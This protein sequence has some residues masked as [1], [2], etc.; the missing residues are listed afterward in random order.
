MAHSTPLERRPVYFA[1]CGGVECA[2]LAFG[3]LIA[4]SI[5]DYTTWRVCFYIVIP[6]AVVDIL[7]ILF[8]TPNSADLNILILTR[9]RR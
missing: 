8:G 1:I 7:I 2:A 5:A 6:L 4:G 9:K 3:P